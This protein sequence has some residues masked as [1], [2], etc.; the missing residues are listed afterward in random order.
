M[1]LAR[2]NNQP[3]LFYSLQGEGASVGQPAIFVRLFGCNL[4]CRW[5]DTPH[6]WDAEQGGIVRS[7]GELA[8]AI[9]MFPCRR[10]VIT[11]GE[12]LIQQKEL[13]ELAALLDGCVIEIETNGTIRPDE[14][15]DQYVTQY[16]I[17]PKLPH[18]GNKTPLALKT[19]VLEYFASLPRKK[20]WFKFVVESEDDVKLA[21]ELAATIGIDPRQ[22]ILM[23][24][25][26][27]HEALEKLRLPV[28]ELAVKYGF[29][30]SDRLHMTLWA[31]RKGV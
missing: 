22:I 3:E 10:I 31:N 11:G 9:A 28:A 15:L 24:Q 4:G 30:F 1:K 25:A 16:N 8:E 17:S 21:S 2:L 7:P 26:A 13:V 5:C 12:P 27:T 20:A 18:S 23:P 6:S 14:R 19:D 29:R